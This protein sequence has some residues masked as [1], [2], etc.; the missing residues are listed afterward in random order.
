VFTI[1]GTEP[2]EVPFS[3]ELCGGPHVTHTAGIGHV[4]ITKEESVSA[5]VGRIRAVVA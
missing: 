1:G 2:A 5:G 3:R 4:K